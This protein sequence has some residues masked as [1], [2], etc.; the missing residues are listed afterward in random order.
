M[1]IKKHIEELIEQ[2]EMN[3]KRPLFFNYVNAIKIDDVSTHRYTKNSISDRYVTTI[4]YKH[5]SE[6]S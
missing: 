5:I 1:K 2:R 4:F 3:F 6:L